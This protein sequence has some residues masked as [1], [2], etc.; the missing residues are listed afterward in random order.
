V[1][2]SADKASSPQLFRNLLRPL[3]AEFVVTCIDDCALRS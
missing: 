1:A 3:A 2:N